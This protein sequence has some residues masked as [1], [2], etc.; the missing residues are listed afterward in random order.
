MNKI[1]SLWKKVDGWMF[2]VFDARPDLTLRSGDDIRQALN[3]G[4]TLTTRLWLSLFSLAAA[5][6]I[7]T[8]TQPMKAK[9]LVWSV[10]DYG[11][12]SAL[13]AAGVLM[14]WRTIS[15][16]SRPA[17]GWV[18]NG[19]MTSVWGLVMWSKVMGDGPEALLGYYT[20]VW[21]MAAWVFIRTGATRRDMETT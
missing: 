18:S 3:F 2:A 14:L 4:T 15:P 6:Q 19:L 20:F 9:L 16:K 11:W 5:A 12:A 1:R 10:P 7:L 17:W 8:Q 13:G 21:L